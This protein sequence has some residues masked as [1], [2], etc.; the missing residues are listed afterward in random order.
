MTSFDYDVAFSFLARDEGIATALNDA[1]KGGLKTFLYSERQKE[2]AGTDGELTFN[3]AFGKQAR[4]V[5]VLFRDGWGETPWTRI[6]QT[7]VRNRAFEEGFDFCL[8]IKLDGA[9]TVPPWLPRA[10]LWVGF[11]RFGIDGASAVIHARAQEL[12]STPHEESLV[13]RSARHIREKDFE[14][15]RERALESFEGVNAFYAGLDGIREA[16][17]SSL[18]VINKNRMGRALSFHDTQSK[19]PFFITGLK[20]GLSVGGRAPYMNVLENAPLEVTLW[21]GPPPIPGTM[22]FDEPTKH[23][24]KKYRLDF[25]AS[26][27]YAWNGEKSFSTSTDLQMADEILKFYFDND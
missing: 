24:T 23:K 18:S 6:E 7:A 21:N 5:V 11:E 27:G 17:R 4:F 8:M 19:G 1:L 16:V 13:E 20:Y 2:L 22:W 3:A 14:V 9:S 26:L 10:R 25:L 12:G 15:A